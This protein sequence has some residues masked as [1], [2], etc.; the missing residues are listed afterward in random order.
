MLIV[1]VEQEVSALI[2]EWQQET[3]KTFSVYGQSFDDFVKKRQNDYVADKENEKMQRVSIEF[4]AFCGAAVICCAF[5]DTYGTSEY[6]VV[7][8]PRGVG[9]QLLML[10]F[11]R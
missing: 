1:Q 10:L 3:G 7:H 5:I 8:T 6:L 4:L 11:Q 2:D 9:A